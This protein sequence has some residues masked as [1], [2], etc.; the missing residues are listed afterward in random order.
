MR[1]ERDYASVL[2]HGYSVAA[3]DA[4]DTLSYHYY[5]G[6]GDVL[7]QSLVQSRLGAEVER[8]CRIVE[9]KYLRTADYRAGYRY[10]LLL[11]AGERRA[12]FGDYRV[13]AVREAVYETVRLSDFGG[14]SDLVVGRVGASPADVVRDRS[15][16]QLSLLEDESYLMAERF[17]VV[18]FD[19]L[20][21]HK[22]LSAV[23]V[24]EARDKV[25]ERGF[26]RTGRA[27]DRDDLAFLYVEADIVQHR[28][29]GGVRVTE[30][31]VPE[32]DRAAL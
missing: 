21:V 13:V 10:S 18:I 31:D 16:E 9:D 25:D 23:G 27:D 5:C 20:A 32:L 15:G 17:Q 6:A 4:R 22:H 12:L 11:T 24:I 19:V 26:S 1:S 2:N 3:S 29:S 7:A 28:A 14:F 30:I 8:A